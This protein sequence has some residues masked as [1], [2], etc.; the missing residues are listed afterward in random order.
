MA[1]PTRALGSKVVVIVIQLI[2]AVTVIRVDGPTK[3][4]KSFGRVWQSVQCS[5][6]VVPAIAFYHPL[7]DAYTLLLQMIVTSPII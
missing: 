6:P 7:R 1:F 3:Q 2:R 5:L 4:H